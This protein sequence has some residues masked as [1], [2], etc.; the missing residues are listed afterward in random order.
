MQIKDRI[1]AEK[2]AAK[3]LLAV[4]EENLSDEQVDELKAHVAEA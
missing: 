3:E 2:K 4:G 1:A